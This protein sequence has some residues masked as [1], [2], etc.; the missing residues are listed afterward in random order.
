[1][2][3]KKTPEMIPMKCCGFEPAFGEVFKKEYKG[4][5]FE[6]RCSICGHYAASPNKW[7]AIKTWNQN[8]DRRL[9]N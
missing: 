4:L 7:A 1:V 2:N 9:I 5:A 6:L 3:E 8:I